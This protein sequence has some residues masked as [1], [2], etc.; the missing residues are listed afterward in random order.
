MTAYHPSATPADRAQ[1]VE[2]Q[3]SVRFRLVG[4]P[5]GAKAADY[6]VS[7]RFDENHQGSDRQTLSPV[8]TSTVNIR[9]NSNNSSHRI[10]ELRVASANG[11]W[12]GV[13]AFPA[14][15]RANFPVNIADGNVLLVTM[16][17]KQTV[18]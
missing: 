15:G 17:A 6:R 10:V 8:E 9:Y 4:L 3:A 5:A 13:T 7:W 11:H 18:D 16:K 2:E 12:A 1:V 14:F